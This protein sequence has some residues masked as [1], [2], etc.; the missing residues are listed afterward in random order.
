MDWE[1][2]QQAKV[3][4]IGSGGCPCLMMS[5]VVGDNATSYLLNQ[6]GR[7]VPNTYASLFGATY[8][9]DFVWNGRT[10]RI[11]NKF[12]SGGHPA[13]AGLETVYCAG[14]IHT[15][16]EFFFFNSGHFHPKRENAIYFV[17]D[18][19]EQSCK[20]LS[21]MPR[22]AMVDKLA[23][24]RLKLY[25]D[26]SEVETYVTSFAEIAGED[27]DE[28]VLSISLI[29]SSSDQRSQAI[30]IGSSS[31]YGRSQPMSIH[32]KSRPIPIHGGNT[33]HT[34]TTTLSEPSSVPSYSTPTVMLTLP[35]LVTEGVTE[36]GKHL[37]SFRSLGVPNWIP[38]SQRTQC[39]NCHKEFG[40][41]RRKHHCRQCGDI[42]CDDCSK[43]T[44]DL[45][46]PARRDKDDQD[47]G[48]YRVCD[49]CSYTLEL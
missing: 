24:M 4:L 40:M 9:S 7:A 5:G 3:R 39:K 15:D 41:F 10:V 8:E 13:L 1:E 17:C 18:F 2:F 37:A 23:K 33:F 30:R 6:K 29:G 36:H 43:R 34:T 35:S 26:R 38:D 25:R 42:F 49:P 12:E 32:G 45:S 44:K 14:E 48:P 28:P 16:G 11:F 27:M 46:R 19:I 31:G 21:G 20:G 47:A 22:D